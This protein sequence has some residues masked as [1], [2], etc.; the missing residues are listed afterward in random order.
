MKLSWF[1]LV[2]SQVIKI[3]RG[4]TEVISIKKKKKKKLSFGKTLNFL[5]DLKGASC[6]VWGAY[7]E[8]SHV[9]R[10]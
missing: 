9:I 2:L 3:I 1:S 4:K 7:V 5:A 6:H 8:G 10:S